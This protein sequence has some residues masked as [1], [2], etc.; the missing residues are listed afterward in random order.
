M[1]LDLGVVLAVSA[2]RT[3]KR[4]TSALEFLIVDVKRRAGVGVPR[5][6]SN[7]LTINF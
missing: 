4:R 2:K 5:V 7:L 6:A 3:S 1:H